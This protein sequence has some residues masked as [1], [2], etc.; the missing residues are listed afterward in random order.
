LLGCWQLSNLG[1][2]IQGWPKRCSSLTL[3]PTTQDYCQFAE[4][5]ASWHYGKQAIQQTD[6]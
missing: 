3:T 2:A 4:L 6:K 1:A 5:L